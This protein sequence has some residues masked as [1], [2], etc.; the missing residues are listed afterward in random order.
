MSFTCFFSFNSWDFITLGGIC[1]EPF[2]G[3]AKELAWVSP[4]C[5]HF[6][7]VINL[8]FNPLNPYLKVNK[9]YF[10]SSF[11]FQ[12][13]N[14]DSQIV[15]QKFLKIYNWR[16][17]WQI[18][19]NNI[20]IISW[21]LSF[22]L[23]ISS[24]KRHNNIFKKNSFFGHSWECKGINKTKTTSIQCYVKHKFL[25]FEIALEISAE[26]PSEEELKRWC[27][28]PVKAAIL[29]TSLFLTNKKG[30]WFKTGSSIAS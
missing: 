26:L 18:L 6:W 25:T 14:T 28:E 21:Y 5:L 2:V 12:E 19:V 20:T 27:G 30:M 22:F 29:P 23:L 16:I 13:V 4:W 11:D 24:T 8:Y 7:F 9:Q 1:L 3:T 17:W 15:C 10:N